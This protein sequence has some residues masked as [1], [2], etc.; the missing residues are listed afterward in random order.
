MIGSKPHRIL[1]IKLGSIGDVVHT[2]PSL[3]TLKQAFPNAEVDWLVEK[4][5]R[6]VLDDNP[7]I[8]EVIEADTHRWRKVWWARETLSEIIGIIRR[9]RARKYDVA[10]DFQGLWKSAAFG[11]CANPRQFIG[12]GAEALKEPG[13]QMFYARRISPSPHSTHI[14]DKYL[15]LVRSLDNVSP[16]YSFELNV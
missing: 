15:D 14:V 12:F 4:K 11:Y 6:T 10:I 16:V 8:H 2:L 3:A 13:C 7:L 5:A 1:I 9:L